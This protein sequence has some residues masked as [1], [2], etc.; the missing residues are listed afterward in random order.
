M[1]KFV[2]FAAFLVSST[3][4]A[5]GA[6]SVYVPFS[7]PASAANPSSSMYSNFGASGN[8]NGAQCRDLANRLPAS[9]TVDKSSEWESQ[10]GIE[11]FGRFGSSGTGSD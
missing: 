9:A 7:T 1:N 2:C 11:G 4:F 6:N 8:G 3:A 10:T 5:A